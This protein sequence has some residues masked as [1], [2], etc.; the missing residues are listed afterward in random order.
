MS[1]MAYDV[2]VIGAGSVGNPAGMFLAQR[3]MKV[4]VI[5]EHA[6]PGQGQNKAAIGGVR[7][8]HSDPAKIMFGLRSLEH[9]SSFHDT[10]GLD[11]GWKKGGYCF[12]AFDDKIEGVLKGLL[13]TQHQYG[14]DIDWHGPETIR[15]AVPGINEHN[16]RGG[17]F[18][19]GD[20]QV[21]PL[22]YADACWKVALNNGAHYRFNETVTGITV[23]SGR[24]TKVTTNRGEYP[25]AAVLNAAGA[26]ASRV[27]AL[28]SLDIPVQPDSHEAG[29]SAP[30]RPFLDPLVVDLRP[31]PEGKTANFYFGQ[32]NE[33]QII[34][35]Y[36]P[37]ELFVGENTES[38]SEFLPVI[39][40]RLIDL[41]PAFQ[42][43]LVRRVWRGLYP[44]TPDGVPVVDRVEEIEGMYLGVGMCGQGFMIGPGVAECLANLIVEGEPTIPP[45]VFA[46][47]SFQRDFYAAKAEALK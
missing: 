44:M 45:D 15:E 41:I 7:A 39:S 6:A 35:C 42:H 17:T 11:I 22:M 26:G 19:P 16:L 8:T 14:L 10:Y 37:K 18:S 28:T 25:T 3:G 47:L 29:I 24:V 1:L 13:G 38:T 20:G 30:I 5:D 4:L 9:F 34:F 43:L 2:V 46:E 27:G 12:P 23:Q 36:T 33:G 21:S 40:R 31:G 32:N